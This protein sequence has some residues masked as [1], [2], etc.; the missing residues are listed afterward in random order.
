MPTSTGEASPI[1]E[2]AGPMLGVNLREERV[3]IGQTD[4]AKS[5]N[6]DLNLTPGT[7]VLRLGRTAINGS[8]LTDLQIRRQTLV[9]GVRYQ[10]AGRYLYR[11]FVR[12]S[13]VLFSPNFNTSFAAYM[14]Q[15]DTTLWTFIADDALMVKDNGTSTVPWTIAAPTAAPVVAIGSSGVLTGSYSARFTYVRKT[16]GGALAAES[17]PSPASNSVTLTNN[18]LSVTGLTASTDSQVTHARLYRTLAGGSDYLFDQDVAMGTT[19]ATSV[20][21]D[22][23]LG[24][25][26]SLTDNSVVP[27]ASSIAIWN[28]TMWFTRDAANPTYLWYSKRFNPESVPPANF[29]SIGDASDPLQLVMPF[30]GLLGVF[31]R[32]TKYRILGNAIS[33]YAAEEAMSRRGTPAWQAA[34]ATE[35]GVVFVARDGIWRTDFS[36]PDVAMSQKIFPLFVGETVNGLDPINWTAANTMR[37]SFFKNRYYLAYPS[38]TNTV[39]DKVMVYSVDSKEWYFYDHP[40]SDLYYE[41]INNQL[42]GG[43][44]D[45]YAYVLENGSSDGGASISL[46]CETKDFFGPSKDIR[47]L[48]HYVRVDADTKGDPITVQLYVDD[49]LQMTQTFTS[50]GR[51]QKLLSVGQQSMG[52]HWRVKFTY[53]G[54][55]RIRIYSPAAVYIPMVFA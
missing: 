7:I 43:G 54:T 10:V 38:G 4:L 34:I 49:V 28:E 22:T 32:K 11:N 29:L 48:F 30:G 52:Y 14:P 41:E 25:E 5:I 15:A 50:S 31:S 51:Q 21:A 47:Q 17:N 24:A 12:Q 39:P 18:Q 44:Q 23:S 36:S 53:T 20:Q 46:D 6:A 3:L 9:N 37:A 33:G 13:N 27:F 1:Q 26:F 2:S 40:M 19:T 35:H 45:G 42:V 16:S 8:P 55:Q